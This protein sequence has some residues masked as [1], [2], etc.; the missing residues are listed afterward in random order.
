[1]TSDNVPDADLDE[2]RRVLREAEDRATLLSVSEK[3]QVYLMIAQSRVD[4]ARLQTALNA[5]P[6]TS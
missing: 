2:A 3:V 6:V 4:I 5:A 1:M